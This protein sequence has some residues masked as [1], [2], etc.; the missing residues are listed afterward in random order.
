MEELIEAYKSTKNRSKKIQ[1]LSLSTAGSV[2]KTM[3]LFGASNYMV[4]MSRTLKKEFGILPEVPHMSK[5]KIITQETKEVIQKFFE[6]DE[7]SRVCPGKKDYK[8][9]KDDK[10]KKLITQKRLV[11]M[12]LKEAYELYKKDDSSNKKVGFSSFAS[13]RPPYCILA[14]SSGTHSV[15]VCTYH[16]NSK[17]QIAALPVKNINYKIL[18]E[19]SVCSIDNKNCMMHMCNT[20]PREVGVTNYLTNLSSFSDSLQYQEIRFKQWIS[21]DRCTLIE[22]TES[23]DEYISS[24]GTKICN[25]TRHHFVAKTQTNYLKELKESLHDN[26]AIVLGDFSEN[27]SFIVQDAAQGFHWENS[28]CT[29]HPFVVY[30]RDSPSNT[31]KHTSFCF[32]SPDTRH[33]TIMV[34]TFIQKLISYINI[35]HPNITKL[36]YFTDGCAGQYKNRYNFSN[37][38]NHYD[39]FGLSCEWHFFATSHGKNAC[40]GI[41]GTIKRLTAKASL[42]RLITDQILNA[43]AMFEF[44][45]QSLGKQI[46]F[47]YVGHEDL[48]KSA[49]MLKSRFDNSIQ[50]PGTQKFHKFVPLTKEKL[51]AYELST[52][53]IGKEFSVN[54]MAMSQIEKHI[55][56]NPKVGEYVLCTYNN[57]KWVG[58]VLLYSEEFDDFKIDFLHPS[59]YNTYYHF[60]QMKDECIVSRDSILHI[61]STPSLNHGTSRIQYK[62]TE[63][64]LKF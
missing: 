27:Y 29:L 31:T 33:N 42:Q 53:T 13:L 10:G 30:W 56:V 55:K 11:L 52:D 12:N 57:K 24:L 8:I 61:L 60:P 17:L 14:G 48:S 21:T 58:L 46:Q 25:L 9:I 1:I 45:K 50:I 63:K 39:D 28:Q 62:F 59:G 64:E 43:Q 49:E 16:Q 41:G 36:H 6:S 37:I 35:T 5:G 4:K 34:Y 15:C 38:C 3:E 32:L 54:K 26:E 7:I 20:C 40:D 51:T 47:F 18:M 22:K 44:C 19:K 2:S 23:I